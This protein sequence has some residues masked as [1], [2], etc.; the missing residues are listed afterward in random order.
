[1]DPLKIILGAA[2]VLI[3][4]VIIRKIKATAAAKTAQREAAA[5]EAA[6]K[7]E[8]K[9][10]IEEEKRRQE[11]SEAR[12]R[13]VARDREL[14]VQQA[15]QQHPAAASWRL[16]SIQSEVSAHLMTVT[17]FTPISKKRYVTIDLET[18]GLHPGDDAIVEIGAVRV[19]NG[20]ITAE[21][22]QLIDPER[23]MPEEASA[24]NH[25]T[26]DMLRGMPKIRQVIPALI[27]FIG[28]DVLVAHNARFDARFIN[29]AFMRN[30]FRVPANWFDTMELA[31]YWPDSP[32]KKLASLIAAAGIENDEAHRA[33][34]DA[35]AVAALVS[36]TNEK[37][38]TK[39]KSDTVSN[40]KESL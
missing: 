23:P 24:V 6:R 14:S 16:D 22:Q 5:R 33:L 30:R 19:E 15:I 35:R 11:E 2:V 4:L 26:D 9:R 13:Q 29:Q 7:E 31:R 18:T 37:R 10:R 32:N 17:E 21:F 12:S 3:V 27:D 36:A 25:I 8:A 34:G 1:M 38:K 28:D 20:Q 39:K 40:L